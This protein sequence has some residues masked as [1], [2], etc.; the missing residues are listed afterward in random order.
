MD[1]AGSCWLPAASSSCSSLPAAPSRRPGRSA[2]QLSAAALQPET[3]AAREL[4]GDLRGRWIADRLHPRQHHPSAGPRARPPAGPQGRHRGDRGQGLLR[5]RGDRPGVDRA[6]RLEGPAGGRQA[7]PGRLDH[8]PA[9][10]PQS[11]HPQ[12]RTDARTKAE[13]SPPCLRTG[14]TPTPSTGS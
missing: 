7:R 10:R 5:P 14:G 6:R 9:A 13:G 11:L 8:H 3:G 4:L 2:S 12:P 1:I